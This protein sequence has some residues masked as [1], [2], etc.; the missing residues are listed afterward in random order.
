M[1]IA[2]S[3][4]D[5][6]FA[7]AERLAKRLQVSRSELY[8]RALREYLA[9]HSPDEVTQALDRVCDE[10]DTVADDFVREAS[11]RIVEGTEW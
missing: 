10:L 6:V 9:R 4:P 2:I 11:R 5:E 1:K 8:S 3:V 7:R